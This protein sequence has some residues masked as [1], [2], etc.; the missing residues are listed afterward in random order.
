MASLACPV[1]NCLGVVPRSPSLCRI[2]FAKSSAE[3][4][5]AMYGPHR[6]TPVDEKDL[7]DLEKVEIELGPGRLAPS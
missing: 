1:S 2:L 3:N 6:F 5:W 7:V 4:D